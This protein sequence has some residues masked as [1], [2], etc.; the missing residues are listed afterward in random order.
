MEPTKAKVEIGQFRVIAVELNAVRISMGQGVNAWIHMNFEHQV[1]P[2]DTLRL[3]TE[4]PYAIPR[5]A[6]E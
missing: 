1:K 6:S 5:P 2:G 4:I 3:F